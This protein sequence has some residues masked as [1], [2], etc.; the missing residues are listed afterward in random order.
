[1]AGNYLFY[2][3]NF[4]LYWNLISR[5]NPWQLRS[6]IRRRVV[7]EIP[8]TPQPRSRVMCSCCRHRW[9]RR[10]IAAFGGPV[11]CH[12]WW[13][14][15]LRSAANGPTCPRNAWASATCTTSSTAPLASIRRPANGTSPAL[16]AA[17][18]MAATMCPAA[19]TSRFRTCARTCAAASTLHSRTSWRPVYPAFSIHW[20]GCSASWRVC[21]WYQVRPPSWRSK[22]LAKRVWPSAGLHRI[23]WLI[24]FQAIPLIWQLCTVLMRM[25]WVARLSTE[26]RLILQNRLVSIRCPRIKLSWR[27]AI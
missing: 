26:R 16:F 22:M 20:V 11:K 10:I 23:N 4:S 6:F 18:R 2:G 21:S 27:S 14:T 15:T 24:A 1:M 17:W 25:S 9:T 5:I 12:R 19:W 13:P 3:L 8:R 7:R